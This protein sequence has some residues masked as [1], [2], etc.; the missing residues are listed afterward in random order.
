[1]VRARTY[2]VRSIGRF[3]LCRRLII[4]LLLLIIVM[5]LRVW[6]TAR[7]TLVPQNWVGCWLRPGCTR[8]LLWGSLPRLS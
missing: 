3:S 8:S 2:A 7:T 1:M 6:E 4:P 5:S